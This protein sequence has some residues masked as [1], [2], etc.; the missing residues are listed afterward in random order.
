MLQLLRLAELEGGDLRLTA[1]G[2]RFVEAGT[3]ARKHL[4]SQ[5]LAT[6]VPLAAH[7][8]RVL[9]DRA[10]HQ[11]PLSRF[12]DEL[13]DHMS[14]DNAAQTL[15]AVISWARYGEYFAYD[16]QAGLLTLDNPT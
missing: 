8:R 14:E 5:Q 11:A 15:R 2:Q 16:E 10:S 6:Y 9:D 1:I 13:E 3:D 12:S 4:L 7:I